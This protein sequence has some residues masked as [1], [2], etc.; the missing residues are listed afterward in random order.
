MNRKTIGHPLRQLPFMISTLIVLRLDSHLL[1]YTGMN[2]RTW[3]CIFEPEWKLSYLHFTNWVWNFIP[4]RKTIY[5]VMKHPT[6]AQKSILGNEPPNFP[7]LKSVDNF[8]SSEPIWE[9]APAHIASHALPKIMTW[10]KYKRLSKI[11]GSKF[12]IQ[13]SPEQTFIFLKNRPRS[14]VMLG[15]RETRWKIQWARVFCDV[16]LCQWKWARRRRRRRRLFSIQNKRNSPAARE[17][18]G[19]IRHDFVPCKKYKTLV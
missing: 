11:G 4:G 3:V 6:W 14:T 19:Q 5:L 16:S 15:V 13:H 17:T 1:K 8:E 2:F 7:T 9:P 12:S 10:P 18:N